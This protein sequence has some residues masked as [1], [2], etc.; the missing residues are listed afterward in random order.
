MFTIIF[1]TIIIST[2][3]IIILV[4]LLLLLLLLDVSLLAS[5]LLDCWAP[6]QV[7]SF[8]FGSG[9]FLVGGCKKKLFATIP[10]V[11]KFN[12]VHIWV[13]IL[14]GFHFQKSKPGINH[15]HFGG[16]LKNTHQFGFV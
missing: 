1:I 3:I 5:W 14:S 8:L 4:L 16:P 2:T 11:V 7:V 12:W 10:G 9:H 6:W 13:N 15:I